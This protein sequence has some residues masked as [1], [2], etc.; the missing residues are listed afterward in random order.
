MFTSG[1]DILA[2]IS[3]FPGSSTQLIHL[4]TKWVI[5]YDYSYSQI[6]PS[7][8]AIARRLQKR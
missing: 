2:T 7:N 5:L 3:L 1:K 4:L 8:R 6:T